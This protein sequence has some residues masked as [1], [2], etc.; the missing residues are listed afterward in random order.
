MRTFLP[1]D[2]HPEQPLE[3]GGPQPVVVDE[4]QRRKRVLFRRQRQKQLRKLKGGAPAAP[5]ADENGVPEE[6]EEEGPVLVVD[7][8]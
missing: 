7:L 8:K 6:G 1:L 4:E 3:L 2:G 5:V